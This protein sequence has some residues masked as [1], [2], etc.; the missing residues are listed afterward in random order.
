M[1]F[2]PFAPEDR[3]YSRTQFYIGSGGRENGDSKSVRFPTWTIGPLGELIASRKVADYR[4]EADFWRDAAIHRLHDVAEMLDDDGLRMVVN[5]QIVLARIA[6][7]QTELAELN[8]IVSDF[9]TTMREC[10][11]AGDTG[12]L[13][14]LLDD[15]EHD[16]G[17]LRPVYRQKLSQVIDT[18]KV[19]LAKMD[20][21]RME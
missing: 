7:R 17:E 19:E 11:E 18:Y 1:T 8:K 14:V 21:T 20:Q 12:L 13:E 5:R 2:D 4:T 16:C 10:V 9:E 15:A 3:G 6:S